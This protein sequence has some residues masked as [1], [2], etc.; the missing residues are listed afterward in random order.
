[1]HLPGINTL[2]VQT[3]TISLI[4]VMTVRL[5]LLFSFHLFPLPPP[6]L[7]CC[8]MDTLPLLLVMALSWTYSLITKTGTR[9]LVDC[10]PLPLSI[11]CLTL[12]LTVLPTRASVPADVHLSRP[13][14][15]RLSSLLPYVSLHRLCTLPDP[16]TCVTPRP[17]YA[18]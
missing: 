14:D 6:F 16:P 17:L 9:C 15:A 5:E 7:Y 8:T 13:S 1:M 18:F 10:A 12:A 11:T 4:P 3:G 2:Y